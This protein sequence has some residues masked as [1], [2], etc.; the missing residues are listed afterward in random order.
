MGN[1]WEALNE[2]DGW[3][4]DT[5]NSTWIRFEHLD[6]KDCDESC[7]SPCLLRCCNEEDCAGEAINTNFDLSQCTRC[8]AYVGT[9]TLISMGGDDKVC[10]ICWDD[11]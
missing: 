5:C 10:E 8:E 3:V 9:E 6:G 11:L 2:H 1:I 7:E 4:C